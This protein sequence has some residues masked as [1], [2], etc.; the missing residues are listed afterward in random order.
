MID[1]RAKGKRGELEASE[2]LGRIGLD[3]RRSAQYCGKAGD[4]DLQCDGV[5]LHVEV[6]LTERMNPYAFVA[7]AVEDSRATRRVP[8]VVARSSYKPWLVILRLDDVPRFVEEMNRANS[9]VRPALEGE[10]VRP[11]GIPRE[12]LADHA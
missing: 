12:P 5:E 8:V 11:E 1:S 10:D 3:C 4:A 9:Q 6:K 7:Q 2:A